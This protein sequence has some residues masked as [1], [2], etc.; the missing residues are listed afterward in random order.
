MTLLSIEVP[1]VADRALVRELTNRL[2][3][4]LV[5]AIEADAR[6]ASPSATA[7]AATK[8]ASLRDDRARLDVLMGRWLSEEIAL[9]NQARLQRGEPLLDAATDHQLRALAYAETVGAGPLQPYMTDSDVEEIDV[10]SHLVTW[11]SYSDGRKVNVGR[12]WES[13]DELTA[14]QRRI[15]LSMGLSETR[16]DEQSP[17]ATIQSPDGSRIVLVLGGPGRSGVSTQPRIA[18]RKFTVHRVGLPGLSA[19]GMF[20]ESIIPQLEAL[21]QSGMTMLISGGPGAGKTTLLKELIDVVSPM[22]RIIT[23]EKG[24]LELRLEDNPLHPDAP[25][26]H[27]RQANTEGRGSTST[28]EL[29]ELTR[30]LNPD[31]VIVGELVE[32]EALEMLDVASMCKRGSMATIH[33]HTVDAVLSRLAFY[34]AKS[35]TKLPEYAVWALIAETVDFV[36]HIDL[37][38]NIHDDAPQRRITSIV[39]FGGR[40]PDGGVRTTETWGLDAA[41]RLVQLNPL[42]ERHLRRLRLAGVPEGLFVPTHFAGTR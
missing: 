33:A 13:A 42:N 29:V 36:V 7:G 6:T 27:T 8:R 25:A 34:I 41:G 14:F 30:R 23:I 22:E 19:M 18:I 9:V 35:N 37:V 2:S 11:V 39:E 32:D 26:L 24:L 12:L 28:R 17:T 15:T 40:G 5:D 20:P 31:R 10:N 21:V 4:R 1:V 3:Q 16:L 38:R